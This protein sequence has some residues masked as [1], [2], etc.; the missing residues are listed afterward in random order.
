MPRP[1]E[2]FGRGLA[3]SP[4]RGEV[5]AKE[6]RVGRDELDFGSL[7]RKTDRPSFEDEGS[8]GQG[9]QQAS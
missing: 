9:P 6:A 4:M 8:C 7:K 5:S 2:A 3:P 1:R